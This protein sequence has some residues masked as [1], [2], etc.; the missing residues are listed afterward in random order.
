[1]YHRGLFSRLTARV[2]LQRVA[3][4]ESLGGNSCGKDHSCGGGQRGEHCDVTWFSRVYSYW[5]FVC[6]YPDPVELVY[7]EWQVGSEDQVGMGASSDG[8]DEEASVVCK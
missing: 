1:M 4:A 2:N 8:V 6:K 7:S 3:F 5:W